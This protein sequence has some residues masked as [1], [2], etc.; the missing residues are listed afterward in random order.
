MR[1]FIQNVIDY[2]ARKMPWAS[3]PYGHLVNHC[4]IA[5]LI[6]FVV[7]LITRSVELGIG[8]AAGFY[9]GRE[10]QQ[11]DAENQSGLTTLEDA[12]AP[13]LFLLVIF[14]I[15]KAV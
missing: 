6:C 2:L 4:I 9:I 13:V 7:M 1:I 5:G 14:F 3:I 15:V 10:F 8:I 12:G 11:Y